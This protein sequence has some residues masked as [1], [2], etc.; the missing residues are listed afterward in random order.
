M[1]LLAL[2]QMLLARLDWMRSMPDPRLPFQLPLFFLIC[3]PSLVESFFV[4]FSAGSSVA[5]SVFSMTSSLLVGLQ[6]RLLVSVLHHLEPLP[7]WPVELVSRPAQARL[8]SF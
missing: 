1:C 5:L 7:A 8:L 4:L 6:N 2:A 3:D